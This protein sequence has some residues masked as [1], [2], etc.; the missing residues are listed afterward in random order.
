MRWFTTL[1]DL[2]NTHTHAERILIFRRK[3]T[4]GTKCLIQDETM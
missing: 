1:L 4:I 3:G 2:E